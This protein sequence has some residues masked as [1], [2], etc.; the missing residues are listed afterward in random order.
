[1]VHDY[2][3]STTAMA[4][5]KERHKE[6]SIAVVNGHFILIVFPSLHSEVPSLES[7]SLTKDILWRFQ[8]DF[9]M[10]GEIH[11]C[12]FIT[13]VNIFSYTSETAAMDIQ[14]IVDHSPTID[15]V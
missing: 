9:C 5:I 4:L 6:P 2:E 15:I 10:V 12:M 11:A 8:G 1:M 14:E 3:M 13:A 7:H